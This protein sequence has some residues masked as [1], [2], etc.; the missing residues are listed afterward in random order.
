MSGG[1]DSPDG[2]RRGEKNDKTENLEKVAGGAASLIIA[3]LALILQIR[4]KYS[5]WWTALVI[6]LC[7]VGFGLLFVRWRRRASATG[8]RGK[9]WAS[10]GWLFF[11]SGVLALT[12]GP[13]VQ[14]SAGPGPETTATAGGAS[15]SNKS[16]SGTDLKTLL[17][18][19]DETGRCGPAG[20]LSKEPS[21]KPGT[22]AIT[23]GT[24][25]SLLMQGSLSAKIVV[26]HIETIVDGHLSRF[27]GNF[28]DL[29]NPCQGEQD[30]EFYLANL[31]GRGGDVSLNPK[32]QNKKSDE[33]PI[34]VSSQDPVSVYIKTPTSI[35]EAEALSWHIEVTWDFQGT[36]HTTKIYN[37]GFPIIVSVR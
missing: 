28:V 13:Q 8:R 21:L 6:F 36:Q 31:G 27:S 20:A 4:E 1:S 35:P 24:Q 30:E 7:V 22:F 12:L 19:P 14:S 33:L 16:A 2:N 23:P 15:T 11:L 9:L 17:T 25:V 5:A 32:A 3:V 29:A 10:A 26:T 37:S 18:V 34:T